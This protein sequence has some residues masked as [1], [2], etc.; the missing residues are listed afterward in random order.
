[1][2]DMKGK[3]LDGWK[4]IA[5]YLGCSVKTVQRGERNRGLPVHRLPVTKG[6]RVRLSP[7]Y[8]MTGELDRWRT[9]QDVRAISESE[10]KEPADPKGR[11]V[12]DAASR[13]AGKRGRLL[14]WLGWPSLL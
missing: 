2:R 10:D 4:D 1:M 9:R 8:A 3:R 5:S 12:K 7:V 14:G 11:P 6:S 13:P